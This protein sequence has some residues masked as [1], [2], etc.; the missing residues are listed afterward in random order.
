MDSTIDLDNF[1]CSSNPL[2]ALEYLLGKEVVFS[3][4]RNSPFLPIIRTKYKIKEISREGDI[5]Y[6]KINS[7]GSGSMTR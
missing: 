7:D 5:I 3:I 2:E 1:D 4:S 6:F